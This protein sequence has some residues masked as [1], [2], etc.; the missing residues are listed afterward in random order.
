MEASDRNS[1]YNAQEFIVSQIIGRLATATLVRVTAIHAAG[2]IAAVG[3]LDCQPMVHQTDG[4]GQP[5]PHGVLNNVPYFRVQGGT[6]AVI[7][8][9]KVGDI[10]IAVFCARDISTVKNSRQ[11]NVPGSGRR[12]DMSDGLFIGG[13]LNGIPQQYVRFSQQG[14]DIKTP[15]KFTVTSQNFNI[16]ANGNASII[17]DLTVS[18][19]GAGQ[20]HVSTH[21]H[22][23][24][25]PGSGES[26]SPKPGT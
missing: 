1:D 16:D 9:P 6:D 7:M 23:G 21:H 4:A 19:G 24:V 13:V 2:E 11:P 12:L 15:N 20:F 22:L 14:I 5:T 18:A 10:G 3:F 25:T 17:G 8:D 26:G